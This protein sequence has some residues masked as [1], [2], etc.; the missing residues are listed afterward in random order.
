M[1]PRISGR[2]RGLSPHVRGNLAARHAYHRV[3]GSIPARA[4]EPW[5]PS[6]PGS[7]CGVYPRTC[8]GTQDE[9]DLG[10]LYVGLS[11]HVRGNP[12]ARSPRSAPLGSIPARAG[13]P[14]SRRGPCRCRRVYPRTCGGT[15]FKWGEG[16]DVPG[17]SPHVRGNLR[18]QLAELAIE[19]SIPARAGEPPVPVSLAPVAAVYPRTCG[20]TPNERKQGD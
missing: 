20:G 1:S 11:P 5:T 15:E 19:G 3:L 12:A 17:L 16:A 9:A 2:S 10:L 18:G 14:G 4:G 13:E 8:G 6:R 7:R